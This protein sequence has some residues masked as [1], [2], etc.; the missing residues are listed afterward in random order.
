M[1]DMPITFR[2]VCW[3]TSPNPTINDEHTIDG[4]GLGSFTSEIKCLD[5]ETTYYARAFATSC[6]ET[7]YGDQV[8]FT[9]RTKPDNF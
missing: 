1:K 3:S 6:V 7:V 8:S 5:G 4:A 2:G 9:Y